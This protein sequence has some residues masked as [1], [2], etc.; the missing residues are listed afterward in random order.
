MEVASAEVYIDVCM[1]LVLSTHGRFSF[2]DSELVSRR[3]FRLLCPALGLW[4]Q[5]WGYRGPSHPFRQRRE[6]R[7]ESGSKPGDYWCP[8]GGP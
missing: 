1:L 4:L 6:I 5:E 8:N 2:D 3:I 7:S